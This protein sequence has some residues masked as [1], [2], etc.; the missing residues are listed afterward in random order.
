M[1][2]GS[3]NDEILAFVV[4]VRDVLTCGYGVGHMGEH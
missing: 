4:P 2:K 3:G 1:P